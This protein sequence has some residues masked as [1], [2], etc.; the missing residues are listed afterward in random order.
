[1]TYLNRLFDA[2]WSGAEPGKGGRESTPPRLRNG[3]THPH[4]RPDELA[5]RQFRGPR[6]ERGPC[7]AG[8]REG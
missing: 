2:A 8:N 3:D 5:E 7:K 4:P 1:M 6:V